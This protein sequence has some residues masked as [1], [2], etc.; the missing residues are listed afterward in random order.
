MIRLLLNPDVYYEKGLR[1]DICYSLYDGKVYY[2][3]DEHR[4]IVE[5][6][7]NGINE[8]EFNFIERKVMLFFENNGLGIKDEYM[9]NQKAL[10]TV[11]A[12]KMNFFD[13]KAYERLKKLNIKRCMIQI[14]GE[15]NYNCEYCQSKNYIPCSCA[16]NKDGEENSINW[17]YLF[18]QLKRLGVE[19]I[20]IIGGEP[21][22][23][24]NTINEILKILKRLE[25][26]CII[27]TN[28]S[29]LKEDDI[30]FLGKHKCSIELFVPSLNEDSMKG[31]SGICGIKKQ[32]ENVIHLFNKYNINYSIISVFS[33][34]TLHE[35][36]DLITEASC[37]D[38]IL[39]KSD[40][41]PSEYAVIID[42]SVKY[43]IENTPVNYLNFESL[44]NF[45]PCLRN[46]IFINSVGDIKLC[47]KLDESLGNVSET[48]YKS[49]MSDK[50]FDTW[51]INNYEDSKCSSC[52]KKLM[53]I[54]CKANL[55]QGSTE[56]E[57]M[58]KE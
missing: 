32:I 41:P 21:Y 45:N 4:K 31:I 58:S 19:K 49:L 24:R 26:G 35:N 40:L 50:I 3:D 6:L 12:F 48:L 8:D 30:K 14:T 16:K 51:E 55:L 18:I 43:C 46:T 28:G 39:Y 15:C 29:L 42:N 57:C 22:L 17:E 56:Y 34:L 25:I 9:E 7:F 13:L 10:S 53:C 33:K 20:N 37:K 2:F 5:K 36:K 27:S 47:Q 1:K 38:K 11:E 54:N 52:C 44:K 23:K